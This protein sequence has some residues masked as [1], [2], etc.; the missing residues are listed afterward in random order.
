MIVALRNCPAPAKLNRFLHVTGRRSDGYHLLETVFEMIDL[1]DLLHFSI[2]QDAR[3]VRHGAIPELAAGVD[4][5]SVRAA[6]LLAQESGT[7]LGVDIAIVKRIPVGGGLGGGSSD[8][9]TTL[10]ALNRLWRLRWTPARLARLALR[11]GADV[12][13]FVH[14]NNAYATGIGEQLV[15]L[16][17]PERFF[18]VVAPGVTV[19]TA[20]VFAAPELTRDTKLIKIPGLSR[21]LAVSEG[22]NDLEPVVCA[23]FPEVAAALAA[24]R[25]EALAAAQDPD[26][27]R[28]T[29]SGSCVFLPVADRRRGEAIRARIAAL[30][31]G[32]AFVVR[33]L[34]SHPLRNWAFERQRSST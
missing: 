27:A 20:E 17:L 29:G 13:V 1:C 10:L 16:P 7:A 25:R 28:M 4:D 3:I 33:S 5:L 30:G 11:L 8:A 6:R 15:A 32:K 24:L 14:G 26:T 22:R 21:G 23:R 12:P 18:V 2:R 9:A 19:S 34:A 31:V